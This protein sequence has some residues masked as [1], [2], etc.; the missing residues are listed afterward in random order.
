MIFQGEE[1]GATTPFLYFTDHDDPELAQAVRE[2]RRA[3]FASFSWEPETIPDPQAATTFDRSKLDWR[4]LGEDH[5]RDLLSWH[6]EL[7]ALRRRVSA[8]VVG[9]DGRVH[10]QVDDEQSS[11]TMARGDVVVFASLGARTARATL[12]GDLVVVTSHGSHRRDGDTLVVDAWAVVVLAR[13]GALPAASG[14]P[15]RGV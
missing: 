14:P 3:E 4:R 13:D 12:P 10:V 11:L 9:G 15:Q 8:A 5:H 6:T 7:I 2:G 1:W